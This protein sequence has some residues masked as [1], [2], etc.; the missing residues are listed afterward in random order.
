MGGSDGT[1]LQLSPLLTIFVLSRQ[2]RHFTSWS[3][4]SSSIKWRCLWPFCPGV[5]MRLELQTLGPG[6]HLALFLRHGQHHNWHLLNTDS[7]PPPSPFTWG[8]LVSPQLQSFAPIITP[9]TRRQRESEVLN[10]FSPMPASELNTNLLGLCSSVT[11]SSY[12]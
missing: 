4:L 10:P 8:H 3:L 11:A 1:H 9:N 12:P 5:F 2:A 7:S 6:K